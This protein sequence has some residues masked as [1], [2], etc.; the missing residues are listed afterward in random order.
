MAKKKSDKNEESQP[1]VVPAPTPEFAPYEKMRNELGLLRNANYVYKPSGFVDWFKMIN[2]DHLKLNRE[3]FLRKDP[4]V[5]IGELTDEE[6]LAYKKRADESDLIITLPGFKELA[7][8]RGYEYVRTE[9]KEIFGRVAAVCE[10]KWIPNFETGMLPVITTGIADATEN[11]VHNVVA[12]Y[13]CAIAENRAFCRAVRNFLQ[14]HSAS[15]DEL[16]FENSGEFDI[17]KADGPGPQSALRKKL[18]D[19][20]INFAD[21]QQKCLEENKYIGCETWGDFRDIPA[22]FATL[23][24]SEYKTLF[25]LK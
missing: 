24:L 1:E 13:L 14:I 19:A 5:E 20:K 16:K 12:D 3:L 22:D 15:Q 8:L 2:P 17:P 11:N 4:P 10:I 9:I 6:I 18:K 25:N 23:L 7:Q 21:L